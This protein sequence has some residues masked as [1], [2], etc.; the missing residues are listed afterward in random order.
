MGLR[1]LLV[2]LLSG[3]LWAQAAEE[4]AA[5]IKFKTSELE[6]P[7]G[8]RSG[9]P[10]LTRGADG[11]TYLA[12]LEDLKG[13]E[14]RLVFA[15]LGK[16][17]W[18]PARSIAQGKDWFNNWADRPSIAALADGTLVA[19]WLQRLGQGTY[20]YGVRFS[21][22][23]DAGENW[24]E[25]RWLHSDRRAVEHGF[26]SFAALDKDTFG[27]V[28]LDGRATGLPAAL[29]SGFEM[30][31]QQLYFRTI[32]R[33]GKLGQEHCIDDAVCDCCPTSLASLGAGRLAL[34]YR[35]RTPE[36]LRDVNLAF[37]GPEGWSEP[38]GMDLGSWKIAGC[39]VNG[40][41]LDARDGA[42]A[43]AWYNGAEDSIGVFAAMGSLDSA[44]EASR[45]LDLGT[46]EGRASVVAWDAETLVVGWLEYVPGGAAWMLRSLGSDGSL[47]EALTLTSA[48]AERSSGYGRLARADE[49]LV[50]AWT[51]A[52][53]SRVRCLRVQ[54]AK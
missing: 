9:M 46:A 2:V 42:L 51:D 30:G 1:I 19:H 35:D 7:A 47:G 21:L 11:K 5:H 39:P 16:A 14:A 45:A 53:Q 41:S 13:P 6:S 49:G 36:E 10:H 50:F 33:S 54:L 34:A 22:S 20:A 37:Y 27:A 17:G 15:V 28:W 26:A 38:E 12:W 25:P 4:P 23:R 48:T 31:P 32:E 29:D 24:D 40:P 43:L 44:L 8:E 3:C 52:K 18:G